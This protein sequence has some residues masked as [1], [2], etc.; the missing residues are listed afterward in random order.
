MV[1]VWS[2]LL[3]K[4]RL[5]KS[6]NG[7]TGRERQEPARVVAKVVF[8][9]TVKDFLQVVCQKLGSTFDGIY[10]SVKLVC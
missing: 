2:I 8:V 4:L 5:C 1:H 7:Q 9:H 3:L 6:N 10:F